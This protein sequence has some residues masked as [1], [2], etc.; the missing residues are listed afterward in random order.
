MFTGMDSL[1]ELAL[2]AGRAVMDVYA[3]EFDVEIKADNSPLT[4]A[5]RASHDII[6]RGLTSLYPDIPL[7]SEEGKGTPYEE[8]RGWRRFWLVDPLDGTKEFVKRNGDFT[9][10]IALIDGHRPV[11]G[12]IYAPVREALYFAS[13]D[14]G[15]FRSVE[16]G[17]PVKISTNKTG[18]PEG[19][20]VAQSRSHPSDKLT[21]FLK[22]IKVK[23]SVSVGSSL[24]FCMVAEGAADIYPRMGPTWEWDTAAGHAIVEGAGGR[25]VGLD[26]VPLRYNKPDLLNPGFI[27][28]A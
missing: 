10:N 18:G 15:A 16:G 19:L 17:D 27:V 22:T 1:I 7:I 9:V 11:L 6:A 28:Y 12:V 25:V 2:S 21:E 20:V 3:T 8:R 24:K 4:K 13:M 23:G 26:G 5:D 14:N